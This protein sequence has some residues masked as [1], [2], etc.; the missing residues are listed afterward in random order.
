MSFDAGNF[1]NNNFFLAVLADI[2][3]CRNCNKHNSRHALVLKLA[4]SF[5]IHKNIGKH[6]LAWFPFFYDCNWDK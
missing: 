1:I 4:C 2:S 3:L 5:H 6:R